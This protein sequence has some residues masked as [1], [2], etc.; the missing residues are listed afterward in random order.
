MIDKIQPS[1]SITKIKGTFIIFDERGGGTLICSYIHRLGSFFGSK[2]ESHYV[3]F[4]S[5][6]VYFWRHE[7]FVDIFWGVITKFDYI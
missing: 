2:F 7:D 5:E 4:F 1:I 6:N 3:W